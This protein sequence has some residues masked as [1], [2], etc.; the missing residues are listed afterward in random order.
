M[1]DFMNFVTLLVSE[2]QDLFPEPSA[3][4][5]ETGINILK[6]KTYKSK[7][8]FLLDKDDVHLFCGKRSLEMCDKLIVTDGKINC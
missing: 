7:I 2:Q 3:N 8:P 4:I 5:L 1:N 6:A